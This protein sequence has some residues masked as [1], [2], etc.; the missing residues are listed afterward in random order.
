MI[1]FNIIILMN[2]VQREP[3]PHI[4]VPRTKFLPSISGKLQP[5]IPPSTQQ[6][7]D[8]DFLSSSPLVFSDKRVCSRKN[9][10]ISF[11]L[12]SYCCFSL[13]FLSLHTG[14]T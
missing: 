1:Y 5:K 2:N 3:D 7:C 11:L 6:K 9:A 12:F 10:N 13:K 14:K 4:P 8:A